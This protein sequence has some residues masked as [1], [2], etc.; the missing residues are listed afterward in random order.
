M[1]GP[2]GYARTRRLR[3]GPGRTHAHTPRRARCRTCQRTHVLAPATNY[4]RRPD[5]AE[6]VGAALLGAVRGLGYRRVADEVG[7]PATTVRGWLQRARANS[8][9]IRVNATLAASVLDPM[10]GPIQPK[11][12]PLADMV[13]AVGVAVAAR[14]RRLGP[15]APPW[16]L[17]LIITVGGILAPRVRQ[18]VGYPPR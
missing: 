17:A 2:W 5:S 11:G 14:V 3:L 13:E 12:S 9:T 10:L 15:G 7:V 16:Q 1:L 4:P 18:F 8:E 6:T